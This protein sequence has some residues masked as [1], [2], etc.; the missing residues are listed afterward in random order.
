MQP[1]TNRA[2][3]ANRAGLA[4]QNQECR[5]EGVLG[6]LS[7]NQ[8]TAAHPPDH[9]AMPSQQHGEGV[10]VALGHKFVASIP[11]R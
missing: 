9:R 2:F 4:R 3:P 5:L 8:D 10:L 11:D 6:I 1:R 7:M